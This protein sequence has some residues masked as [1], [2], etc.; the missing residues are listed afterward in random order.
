M[1]VAD[2][3]CD[4]LVSDDGLQHYRLQ[5][6]LEILVVDGVRGFGNGLCL[7]AGPLREPAARRTEVD[8]TVC[9]GGPCSGG[10]FMRLVAGRLVNLANPGVS[11]ALSDLR[12][13]RV[14]AVA[15]TG[16]PERFFALLRNHGLHLDERP[17]PDHHRFSV[18]DASSWPPGPVVMT[19]KDAVKCERFARPDH[20]YLPVEARMDGGFEGE[21][22]DRLKGFADG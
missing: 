9:S 2:G 22:S 6:D 18:E 10:Q 17:Y 12:R 8:L 19:E 16:N 13:Q 4:I 15:G 3:G 7:P 1:L 21:V 20:W 14:T 5:R 11:R